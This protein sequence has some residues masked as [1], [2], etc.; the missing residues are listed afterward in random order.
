VAEFLT[1]GRRLPFFFFFL[2]VGN[3]PSRGYRVVPEIGLG[4]RLTLPS[5]DSATDPATLEK[6]MRLAGPDGG[7]PGAVPG[8]VLS[9]CGW[10]AGTRSL[11]SGN[12]GPEGCRAHRKPVRWSRASLS[13]GGHHHTPRAGCPTS[14][15]ATTTSTGL[16]RVGAPRV[17]ETGQ[18]DLPGAFT[19]A[20]NPA[21]RRPAPAAEVAGGDGGAA[22]GV[23]RVVMRPSPRA[24]PLGRK[25]GQPQD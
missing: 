3:A 9:R 16:D 7:R 18:G 5:R 17:G 19:T 21:G 20:D 24:E 12:H 10:P 6:A 22:G 11:A 8:E 14:P 25:G 23:I 15:S 4:T 1:E 13:V 2:G